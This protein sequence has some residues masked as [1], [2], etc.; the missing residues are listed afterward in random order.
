MQFEYN[1]QLDAISIREYGRNVQRMVDHLFTIEDK[2]TRSIAAADVIKVMNQVN[3]D[4]TKSSDYE[5]KLWDHLHMMAHYQ[6][7]VDSPYEKPEPDVLD[8]R[9]NLPSYNNG[10]IEFKHYGKIVEKMIETAMAEEE[11][12]TRQKM[13]EYIAGYMKLAYKSWNEEKV[14][15][16]VIIQNLRDLSGGK[17]S[18]ESV[19]EIS[20]VVP[21]AKNR[22]TNSRGGNSNK[23][24]KNNNNNKR[25]GGGGGN[26]NRRYK[27]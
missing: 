25:K 8:R 10:R 23:K 3:P 4:T 18:V 9:P 7:D 24:K 15:D 21:Q 5:H 1:T 14:T 11:A 12:E 26:N 2:D 16:E 27:R 22:P 19:S 13:A 6:L 17:L 20:D